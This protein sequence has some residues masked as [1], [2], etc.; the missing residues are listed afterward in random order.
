MIAFEAVYKT[1]YH[2]YVTSLKIGKGIKYFPYADNTFVATHVF[3]TQ[4]EMESLVVERRIEYLWS[5][6]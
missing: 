1:G 3:R 4:E 5:D 6:P 2:K